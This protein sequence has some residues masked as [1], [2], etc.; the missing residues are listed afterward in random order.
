MLIPP[1]ADGVA[2][3]ISSK[4]DFEV[5]CDWKLNNSNKFHQN[6]LFYGNEYLILPG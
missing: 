2:I 3:Y 1:N 6:N 5:D 4:F